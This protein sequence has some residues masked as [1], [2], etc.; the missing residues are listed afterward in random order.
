MK[1]KLF[2]MSIVCLNLMSVAI[3]NPKHKPP[4]AAVE[5]CKN[6]AEGDACGNDKIKGTC[7]RAEAQGPLFCKPNKE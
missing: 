7:G 1:L 2:I 3:A 4:K 5:D 6:K